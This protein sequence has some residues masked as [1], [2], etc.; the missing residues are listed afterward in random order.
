MTPP[1]TAVLAI[2][3]SQR[4]QSVAVLHA[5]GVDQEPVRADRRDVEDLLPAIDRLF[6]RSR[7]S[8]ASLSAVIVDGGP[9][10]FTG[11]RMAH[12]A[13]QAMTLATGVPAVQVPAAVVA[14][15]VARREG[16]LQAGQATWVAL[17]CKGEEAWTARID[18][19]LEPDA[20]IDARSRTVDG[21]DPAEVQSLIAD[22]HLP[23]TWA[24]ACERRGVSRV[25]LRLDATGLL[26]AGLRMLA[27]GRTVP[28]RALVPLY[29]RE[30]EAVRLWRE[31]HGAGADGT[32]RS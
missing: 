25:P 8:P 26:A 3:A 6:R 29:P 18:P 27:G 21:W 31:R 20:A 5:D 1:R 11:L 9:G 13:A 14:A 15:E 28:G 23:V 22:E 32:P 17:A 30:A 12:A 2:E 10:G 19:D 16:R 7:I 4:E 24:E